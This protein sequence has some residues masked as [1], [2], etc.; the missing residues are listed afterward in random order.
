M[1]HPIFNQYLKALWGDENK[2]NSEKQKM[3]QTIDGEKTHT[4]RR[5]RIWRYHTQTLNLLLWSIYVQNIDD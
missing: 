4:N 3:K 1:G 5:F 2:Y